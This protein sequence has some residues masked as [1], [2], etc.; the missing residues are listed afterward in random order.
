MSR[1]YWQKNRQFR[2]AEVMPRRACAPPGG[3][4]FR[5]GAI[6]FDSGLGG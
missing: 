1:K 4:R 3:S 2:L 6:L 5:V